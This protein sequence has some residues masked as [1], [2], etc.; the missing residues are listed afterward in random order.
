[1]QFETL[2]SVNVNGHDTWGALCRLEMCTKL[3]AAAPRVY[4]HAAVTS[5]NVPQHPQ[6]EIS[7][8]LK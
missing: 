6:T 2:F 1:M 8:Q 3:Q 5:Q 7:V 4:S